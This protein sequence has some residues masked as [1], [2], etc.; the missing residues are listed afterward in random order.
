MVK[1]Y[2]GHEVSSIQVLIF[3]SAC[4]IVLLTNVFLF[5]SVFYYFIGMIFFR[6]SLSIQKYLSDANFTEEVVRMSLRSV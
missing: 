2:G 6:R 3:V 5:K 1:E 4:V